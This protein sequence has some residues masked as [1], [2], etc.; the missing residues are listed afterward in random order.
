MLITGDIRK[1]PGCA[2][3]V[4]VAIGQSRFQ[5]RPA[6]G[7]LHADQTDP[8]SQPRAAHR[9]TQL[10]AQLP[11]YA[12]QPAALCYP[13]TGY[14]TGQDHQIRLVRHVQGGAGLSEPLG[15]CE[16]VLAGR[17][18]SYGYFYSSIINHPVNSF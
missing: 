13:G 16:K 7:R 2:A 3:Q 5:L 9:H 1:Q 11:G 18:L 6:A 4:S 10:C 12:V 14:F 8:G 15:G 17:L